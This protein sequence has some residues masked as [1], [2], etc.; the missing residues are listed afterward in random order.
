MKNNRRSGKAQSYLA[1][2]IECA[3][4][5]AKYSR[6]TQ[7]KYTYYK[8]NSRSKKSASSIKDTNCKNKTWRM[9][10]LDNL[11]FNEIKKLA[12]DPNR[13]AHINNSS[14][15]RPS[16]IQREIDRLDDQISK[17][18]SLYSL[19]DMPIGI[20]QNKISD[21]NDQ[22]TNLEDELQSIIDD[23]KKKATISDAIECVQSF[24]DIL[25]RGDID[26]I[27]IVIGALIE[28]IVL[29]GDDFT[30]YWRFA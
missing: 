9:C 23:E 3:H 27:R 18:I 25:D 10:D 20:L 24:G 2:Y 5:G 12:I 11:I 6:I 1:G 26:E 13:I 19:Q 4:C 21:L 28:K 17:L 22:K 15:E 14:D 29:D 7:H 30:I 8:C 16:I